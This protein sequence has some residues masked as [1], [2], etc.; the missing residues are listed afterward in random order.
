MQASSVSIYRRHRPF[1]LAYVLLRDCRHRRVVAADLVVGDGEQQTCERVCRDSGNE[2][3][4]RAVDLSNHHAHASTHTHTHT[5]TRTHT[6]TQKHARTHART[7]RHAHACIHARSHART[8]THAR[9][10]THG[11]MHALTHAWALGSRTIGLHAKHGRNALC[12]AC[13]C[14]AR[15][16][17][18]VCSAW[19]ARSSAKPRK[20]ARTWSIWPAN[21]DE[22]TNPA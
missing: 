14:M 18:G 17:N 11:Q 4:L 16:C 12:F 1:P 15:A 13:G 19:S 21:M 2:Q 10:Q 20:C 6:L 8:Q 9:K 7:N 22:N 5:H 3:Q